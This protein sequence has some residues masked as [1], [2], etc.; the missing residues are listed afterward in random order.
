M[1]T[2]Y[3][4]IYD[5]KKTMSH[6]STIHENQNINYHLLF[7]WHHEIN[8]INKTENQKQTK[9]TNH[10][11]VESS[12]LSHPSQDSNYQN[13][14][15]FLLD[16]PAAIPQDLQSYIDVKYTVNQFKSSIQYSMLRWAILNSF[17][18][19]FLMQISFI[20]G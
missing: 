2:R 16:V 20:K 10:H 12:S 13:S 5:K 9:S 7:K 3:D 15:D 1:Q 6:T 19:E 4:I 18:N 11:Q 17:A 8:N 14:S